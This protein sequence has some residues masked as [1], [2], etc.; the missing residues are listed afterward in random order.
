MFWLGAQLC[1]FFFISIFSATDTA[2]Q[3]LASTATADAAAQ[4]TRCRILLSP[5]TESCQQ[6]QY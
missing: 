2:N 1:V 6:Q 4:Q 5:E 3:E